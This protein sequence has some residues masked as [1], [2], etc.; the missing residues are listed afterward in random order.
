M[1]RITILT[2]LLALLLTGCG[3]ANST[4]ETAATLTVACTTYPVYL[5]ANS[6]VGG[7]DGVEAE[8]V[9]DQQ[10]SCLHDYTLTVQDM[11]VVERADAVAVNGAGLEDFLDDVLEGRTV[12]DCSQ[13]VE[14]LTGEE[15]HHDGD[16]G[17]GDSEEPDPHIW[18]DPERYAQ[19]ARNLAAGLAEID[20]DREEDYLERGEAVA[21]ELEAFAA[22]L[23]E[24]DVGQAVQGLEIITFHDG[25]T[26]FAEAFDLEIAAA[27][28][29]EE[30]AEA[31]ARELKEIISIVQG[32]SLPAVFVEVNGS[33]N[34][35]GIIS[36]EC[37]VSVRTLSMIMSGGDGDTIDAYE[38]AMT[39]NLTTI[40]EA[41][42]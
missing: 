20:P 33:D 9:I 16:D 32:Q 34:A 11:K 37:G 12:I 23:R 35:A 40:W 42:Q 27:I 7:I 24:S 5:L 17:D 14:L 6:I 15:H 28:E 19:M 41:Y 29:E 30:G 31:S 38:A 22:S 25:F 1:R 36:R 3:S 8:L 21:R 26:Y 39:E 4:D 10:V 18:M 13:D 2:L